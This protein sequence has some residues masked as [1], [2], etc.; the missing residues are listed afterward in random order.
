[1][2]LLERVRFAC[3]NVEP[4]PWRQL[5]HAPDGGPIDASTRGGH[6]LESH[7]ALGDEP[8]H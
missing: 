5:E 7:P 6:G 4:F 3:S 1:L 2:Q 8:N